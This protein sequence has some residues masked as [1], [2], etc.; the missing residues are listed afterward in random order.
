MRVLSAT[1]LSAQRTGGFPLIKAIFTKTGETT[2]GYSF[3]TTDRLIGL[4]QSDQDWLQTADVTIDNSLGN[5]T[6][7]DLTGFQC[8]ISKGY[9]TTVVR[10][11]WAASTVYALLDVVIPTTI[12]GFQYICTVAGTSHSSE[13]TFPTDLGVTVTETGGVEWTMDGNTSDEYSPTAPMKVIAENDQILIGEAR[14]VFSCAG[15]ANQME[16]DEASIE[17]SQDELAVST[18]KTLIGNLTDSVASFAPFSHTEVIST[19][20]GDEDALIDTY[21]PK[22]TYHISSSATRAATVLGLLRLTRMAPRFEDDGKLHIDILVNGD[23]PTWTASTAYIVG[24]TVIPTTPNDN[25]YKCTTAGTSGSSE[26]TFPTTEDQ[27]VNDN[28]VVWTLTYDYQY[29]SDFATTNHQFWEGSARRRLIIPSKITVRSHESHIPQYSGTATD[30]TDFAKLPISKV[31]RTRLESNAQATNLAQA[32]IDRL[33]ADAEQAAL[34][35]PPNVGQE[36]WDLVRITDNRIGSGTVR[37][38]NVRA[39]EVT[40]TPG[41][42]QTRLRF[43]AGPALAPL[44]IADLAIGTSSFEG[45]VQASLEAIT[46]WIIKATDAI[47]RNTAQS[48]SLRTPLIQLFLRVTALEQGSGLTNLDDLTVKS[49]TVTQKLRIPREA[50]DL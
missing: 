25:V 36:V 4:K 11:A 8:I 14:V 6:G 31:F 33:R 35:S 47:N 42:F 9:N 38:G 41:S 26:P 40:F 15:L 7:L 3:T 46:D 37:I 34:L 39:I 32:Q 21:K 27:T 44:G 28:T 1:L 29:N 49:L 30:A 24:D 43:G 2:K 45:D 48:D 19:S 20:Y 12:N 17:F 13:P 16:E 50:E 23:P 10:A 22:D 5:L 18:L